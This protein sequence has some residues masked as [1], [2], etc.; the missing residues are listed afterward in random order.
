MANGPSSH[1]R[2]PLFN[3]MPNDDGSLESFGVNNINHSSS[4]PSLL[5]PST[6]VPPVIHLI[7]TPPPDGGQFQSSEVNDDLTA[8]DQTIV[9]LASRMTILE[10]NINLITTSVNNM[11]S[12]L[13]RSGGSHSSPSP[14]PD[15]GAGVSP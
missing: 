15:Q 12:T 1:F 13:Q 8:G 11:V 5:S 14:A 2:A 10:N 9:T 6:S 3:V 4:T 7:T